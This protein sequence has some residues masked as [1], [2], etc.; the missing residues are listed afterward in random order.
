MKYLTL[1]SA[2]LFPSLVQSG[3]ISAVT[4]FDTS[5]KKVSDIKSENKLTSFEGYWLKKKK[6]DPLKIK[7]QY[8]IDVS[9]KTTSDR[10][11]YHPEG[12]VQVLTKQQAK[13][14]RISSVD[15]F[16]QLIGIKHNK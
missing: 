14:Y 4:V 7:W 16:N 12:W 15:E 10:W 1:I 2:I 6:V 8:L 5:F 3:E 13:T 9:G 11:R